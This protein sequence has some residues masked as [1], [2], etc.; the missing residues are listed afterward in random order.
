L[1]CYFQILVRR[2]FTLQSC[3]LQKIYARYYIKKEKEFIELLQ[4]ISEKGI[5]KIEEAIK[6][7]ELINPLD[8]TTE[9][10]KTICN[11][12]TNAEELGSAKESRLKETEI[13]KKANEMLKAFEGLIPTS[14]EKFNKEVT[15]V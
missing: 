5:E 8:I 3:K 4:L 9:K 14:N 12:Q 11:K 15:I 1:G 7:L 10:I 13:T 2:I 6:T